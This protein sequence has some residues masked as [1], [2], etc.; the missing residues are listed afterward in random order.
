MLSI[1]REAKG[2]AENAPVYRHLG[3]AGQQ[4]RRYQRPQNPRQEEGEQQSQGAADRGQQHALGQ[5]LP[6]ETAAA[7]ADRSGRYLWF[8]AFGRAPMRM[9]IHVTRCP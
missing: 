7:G 6:Y 8:S 9:D 5:Q 2:E 4:E 3:D 1:D